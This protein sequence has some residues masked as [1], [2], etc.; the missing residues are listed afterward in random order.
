MIYG[1]VEHVYVYGHEFKL[2]FQFFNILY[3]NQKAIKQWSMV[4]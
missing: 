3:R 4:T 1:V 2:K